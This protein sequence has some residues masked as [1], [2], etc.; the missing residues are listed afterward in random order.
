MLPGIRTFQGSGV[1]CAKALRCGK[2][3]GV[4]EELKN[5]QCG[6]DSGSV[7]KISMR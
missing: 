1:A 3:L 5:D 6:G 4:F 7:G 2:E